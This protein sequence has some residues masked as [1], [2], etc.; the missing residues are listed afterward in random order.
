MLFI[1]KYETPG[2]AGSW[3]FSIL[4]F[5]CLVNHILVKILH[6]YCT[7]PWSSRRND[8]GQLKEI[9]M[10]TMQKLVATDNYRHIISC[11]VHSSLS[12]KRVEGVYNAQLKVSCRTE[13]RDNQEDSRPR[14]KMSKGCLPYNCITTVPVAVVFATHCLQQYII[15]TMASKILKKICLNIEKLKRIRT[16]SRSFFVSQEKR[17]P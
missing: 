14:S 16:Q 6:I 1:R 11:G 17:T 15:S 12:P 13:N 2:N 3:F 9:L 8:I 10:H 4:T 7:T 5:R